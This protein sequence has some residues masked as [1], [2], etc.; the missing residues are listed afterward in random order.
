MLLVIGLG[1]FAT[2]VLLVMGLA[3]GLSERRR[4]LAQ[5][6]AMIARDDYSPLAG[7]S[8]RR[9]LRAQNYSAIPF[10]QAL[11][12][13][14]PRAE[15]IADDLDRAA[16]PLRVGEYLVLTAGL[17]LALALL[18]RVV[19][20]VGPLALLMPV[21]GAVAG[22]L[23]PPW[24]VRQ[25]Q[26]R[27]RAEIER[28]LPDALDII[29]R[30]LRSGTGLLAALDAVIDQVGGALGEELARVRAEIAASISV[31]DAFREFDRRVGSPDVGIVVTAML[32]QREVGGNLAEIL[33]N[34]ATTMRERVRLRQEMRSLTAEQR[35]SAYVVSGVPVFILG[36]LAVVDYELVRP[37]FE[38]AGG[39]VL[40]AIAAA[41]ELA[42]F[43]VVRSIIASFEV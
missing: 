16:I 7:P 2:V 15:R 18:A 20:S 43:L 13:R 40:L 4:R 24:F 38:E 33:D 26:R 23:L 29:A 25:R 17:A 9:L 6:V 27:R 39:R 37:L 1:A 8:G 41:L 35:I 5:R 31:E 21:V 28:E 22:L 32:I 14:S 42:G 11:L 34:V 30:G 19:F 36:S 3:L 10:L 12:Q